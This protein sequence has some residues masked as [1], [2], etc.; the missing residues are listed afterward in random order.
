MPTKE[1]Q[2]RGVE[3]YR[4][5]KPTP[6]T[7]QH[8]AIVKKEGPRGGKTVGG[9]I[10]R[11][12]RH[13]SVPGHTGHCLLGN[14][15]PPDLRMLSVVEGQ[16]TDGT[17]TYS[18]PDKLDK[19]EVRKKIGYADIEGVNSY[20]CGNCGWAQDGMCEL[21]NISI[22]STACCSSWAKE[23]QDDDEEGSPDKDW[24]VKTKP[25]LG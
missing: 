2:E 22:K 10:H 11:I 5:I 21:W 8:I 17:I 18:F 3:Y 23:A 19:H 15:T 9:P 12:K 25:L 24:I 6:T 20:H 7:Y 13:H 4:T 16:N 1:E 14:D